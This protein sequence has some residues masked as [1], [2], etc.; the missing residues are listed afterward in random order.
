V[1]GQ[2]VKTLINGNLGMG[3]TS[4]IWD[5]TDADGQGVNSGL[6]FYRLNGAGINQTRRMML[7]K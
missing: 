7:V 2:L 3:R 6:Y 1:K 5:G 4:V